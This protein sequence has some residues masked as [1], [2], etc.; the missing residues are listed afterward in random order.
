MRLDNQRGS[1]G[2]D[3]SRL[4]PHWGKEVILNSAEPEWLAVVIPTREEG[5]YIQRTLRHMAKARSD[6]DL[7]LRL[8]VVD[9]NSKDETVKRAKLAD[10][11]VTDSTQ[12][13]ESIGQARNVGAALSR[14]NLIFHTDADVLVPD[15]PAFLRGVEA[16]FRNPDVVGA[17]APVIPYPWEARPLDRLM[18]KLINLAVRGAIPLGAFLALGECQIVR[19]STFEAIGGYDGKIILGE[20]RDFLQR[21]ARQGRIAYLKDTPVLHSGRRYRKLGYRRVLFAYLREGL[22][23]ASGRPSPFKEWTPV[24]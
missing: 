2:A 23:L 15:L 16:A 21:L 5:A 13:C 12:A 22:A 14:S 3:L 19:R 24:R 6:H 1:W 10:I 9:G 18:H 20:D 7:D 4:S 17:T 11:I 8:Y